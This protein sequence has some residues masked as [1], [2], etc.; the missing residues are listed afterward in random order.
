M[1]AIVMSEKAAI[2]L[3]EACRLGKYKL[4]DWLD[5]FPERTARRE[6]AE[7]AREWLDW[8]QRWLIDGTRIEVPDV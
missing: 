3:S 8:G 6:P 5:E 2:E 7:R 4:E 1:V